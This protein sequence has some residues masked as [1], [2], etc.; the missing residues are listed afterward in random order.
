M[1]V[2]NTTT[3]DGHGEESTPIPSYNNQTLPSTINLNSWNEE[4]ITGTN[5]PVTEVEVV[6]C[7]FA[8]L[9]WDKCD[10]DE[11]GSPIGGR[12]T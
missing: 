7:E 10:F 3:T 5:V 8:N 1:N 6:P 2:T 12:L 9:Q 4:N 11:T